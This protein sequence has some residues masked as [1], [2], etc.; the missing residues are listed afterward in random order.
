[1]LATLVLIVVFGSR[2]GALPHCGGCCPSLIARRGGPHRASRRPVFFIVNITTV[3]ARPCIDYSLLILQR[4][5]EERAAG[6]AQADAIAQLV[7]TACQ[8]VVYSMTLV[9]ALLGMFLVPFLT[10]LSVG[11]GAI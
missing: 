9:V 4:Y 5:R 11:L 10:F 1:M 6:R 2:G 8:T 7:P 3:S